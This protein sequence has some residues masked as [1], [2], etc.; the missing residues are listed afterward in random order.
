MCRTNSYFMRH[1]H[2][3]ADYSSNIYSRV[4]V[5]YKKVI[6]GA[7]EYPVVAMSMAES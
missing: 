3:N 1:L 4:Y 2:K 6:M 5:N 7:C